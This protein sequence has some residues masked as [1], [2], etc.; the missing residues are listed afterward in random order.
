MAEP[1]TIARPYAVAAFNF[2]KAKGELA[3]WSETLAFLV[4]VYQH[5]QMQNVLRNPELFGKVEDKIASS[6]LAGVIKGTKG[7]KTGLLAGA[8][9]VDLVNQIFLTL[10]R[11]GR[12]LIANS[13]QKELAAKLAETVAAGLARAERELGRR[14]DAPALPAVVAGLVAAVARGELADI[15]P[16]SG[17]FK[18]L[19]AQLAEALGPVH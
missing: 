10:S 1:V 16:E 4:G 15:D 19:F 11:R 7:D 13:T 9:L 14:L 8:A 3:K 6:V 12:D 5:Q 17:K 2:A 18:E